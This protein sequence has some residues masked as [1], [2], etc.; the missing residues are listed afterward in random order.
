MREFA[1]GSREAIR[2]QLEQLEQDLKGLEQ[3][4]SDIESDFLRKMSRDYD[5]VLTSAQAQAVLYQV[6]GRSIVEA[7][8]AFSVLQLIE[9]RLGEIRATVSSSE[10]LRRY[11]GVAAIMRLIA[12]RLHERHLLDY[13]E[14]W[15]PALEELEVENAKLINETRTLISDAPN[16]LTA[17]RYAA[18]LE[19]Q[20]QIA[21]VINDYRALLLARERI[22]E[23]RL[24]SAVDDA[25]LAVNTLRTLDQAVLLFDQFSWQQ[26]EFEALMA[27]ESSDLIPLD[28]EELQENFLDISRALAGS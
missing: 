7:S 8:V 5:I 15:L 26:D 24:G 16:S 28:N 17:D 1:R 12:V 19:I 10:S 14:T 23:D 3:T 13:R 18:N 4:R 21:R 2:Q 22:V 9:A 27:I 20:N 11:Y 6:N 25:A